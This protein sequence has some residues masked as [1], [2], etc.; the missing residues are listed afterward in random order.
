M[1]KRVWDL[2]FEGKI[3][4]PQNNTLRQKYGYLW[5]LLAEVFMKFYSWD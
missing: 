5:K 2:L 1:Q 3:K 4:M